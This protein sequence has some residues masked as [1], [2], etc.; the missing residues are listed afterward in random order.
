MRILLVSMPGSVDFVDAH[1]RFPNLAIASIAGCLSDHEVKLVDLVTLK[2][3]VKKPLLAILA[4][5]RPQLLGLS[6]MTFQFSSLLRVANLVKQFDPS[7]KIVAGGYHATLMHEEIDKNELAKNL[8]FL[9]RGEGEETMVEFVE[10]LN[11]LNPEYSRVL[12]L[13]FRNNGFWEHNDS[14]PLM[15][16]TRLPLPRRDLRVTTG[17]HF[18]RRPGDV[19]ETSRG[20]PFNCKFC[21]ITHMYGHT[22]RPFP[23]GRV[24]DDIAN[25]KHLG[26]NHIFFSDDN[27]TYDVKHFKALCQ[28]IVDNGHNDVT[29]VTQVSAVGIANNPE[30]VE[31]MDKANFRIVF[32]G[33]ESMDPQMLKNMNKPSNPEI[34]L[35]AAELLKAHNMGVVVGTI[36]GYPD[37]DCESVQRQVYLTQQ[38]NGDGLYLQYLTPYPKTRIREEMLE[39]GLIENEDNFDDYTGMAC[40]TRTKHLSH[41]ELKSCKRRASFRINAGV[42]RNGLKNNYF[43]KNYR[44]HYFRKILKSVVRDIYYMLFDRKVPFKEYDI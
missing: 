26:A 43:Y 17:Y 37:D 15:D 13:S 22:F 28:A 29:Y 9:V 21:S 25:A 23:I 14:R 42:R 2:P 19:V 35:K 38:I 11:S 5:F 12:G 31:Y 39:L 27:L 41:A 4:D 8:D 7:I 44:D 33:F 24:M 30:L 6:A 16:L 3:K 10:Q 32:V 20:C 34:N 40:N 1:M 36:V 18:M